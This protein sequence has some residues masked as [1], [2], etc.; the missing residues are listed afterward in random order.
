MG[1]RAVRLDKIKRPAGVFAFDMEVTAEDRAGTWL[2]YPRGS[3]WKAPHDAGTMPFDALLLLTP[4]QPFV[5]WWV[6]DPTDPRVEIDICLPPRAT[7]A[8]WSFVDLELDPVRH[9][10]TGVIEIEDID[11]FDEA[12]DQGWIAP[13][14]SQIAMAAAALMRGALGERTEP[15]GDDGWRRLRDLANTV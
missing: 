1:G 10:R 11:E 9:E 12:C 14:D 15:W 13:E 2:Y 7:E 6:D 4:D 3:T 5:T 8:G